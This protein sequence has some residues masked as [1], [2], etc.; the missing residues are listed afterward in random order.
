MQIHL[1]CP[2]CLCQLSAPAD[3]PA[4]EILD[5]M[6]DDAPWFALADGETFEDMVL[7]ALDVRGQILCP[8]CRRDVLVGG[9]R[10]G[11]IAVEAP[12]HWPSSPPTP[13]SA[14]SGSEAC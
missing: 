8:E 10:Q 3:T 1:Y 2:D 12:P 6:T 7:A 4:S 11:R 9:K 14:G 5:R 13:R